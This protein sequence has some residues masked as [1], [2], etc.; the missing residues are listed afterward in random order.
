MISVDTN[1]LLA[2]VEPRHVEHARAARFLESLADSD[3]VALSE[4]VLLELYNLIRNPKVVN[5]PLTAKLAARVCQ[6]FRQHPRWQ[7]VGFPDASRALHDELWTKLRQPQFARR[8][9]YDVRMGLC[10]VRQGVSELATVN[11]KDFEGLGLRRVWNPLLSAT[12]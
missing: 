11:V 6:T 9:A 7:I 2:A 10:L 4:F 5:R 8:R 12:D 3:D 1:I